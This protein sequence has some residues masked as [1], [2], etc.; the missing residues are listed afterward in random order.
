MLESV[1]K[2]GI[3]ARSS[4]REVV[5]G[6]EAESTVAEANG[7]QRYGRNKKETVGNHRGTV[8]DSVCTTAT[9]FAPVELCRSGMLG[10]G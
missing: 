10:V 4:A 1:L 9:S 6:R 7:N 8:Q 2:E 3:C 5:I